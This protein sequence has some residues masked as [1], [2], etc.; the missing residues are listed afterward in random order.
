LAEWPHNGHQV[1]RILL[2]EYR[3]QKRLDLRIWFRAEGGELRASRSGIVVP[4]ERLSEVRKGLRKAK[5]IAVE[6][7]LMG[8]PGEK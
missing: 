3:G 8:P 6:L 7:G 2:T 1:V 4:L 5:E